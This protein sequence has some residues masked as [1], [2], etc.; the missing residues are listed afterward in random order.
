M[1]TGAIQLHDDFT[2]M[3]SGYLKRWRKVNAEVNAL[4]EF[5]CADLEE[6]S[7]ERPF[8]SVPTEEN[9]SSSSTESPLRDPS[10]DFDCCLRETVES[11]SSSLDSDED[12]DLI[13]DLSAWSI[14]HR[15]SREAVNELLCILKRHGQVVPQGLT[16]F[17]RYTKI[18]FSC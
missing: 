7:V 10:L 16:H 5:E 2:C 6:T 15:C 4:K 8:Q 14:K 17:T 9:C 1:F 12:L 18:S 13:G 3:A 11:S